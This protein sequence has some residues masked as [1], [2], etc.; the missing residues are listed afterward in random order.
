AVVPSPAAATAAAKK[1]LFSVPA[2]ALA[3]AAAV[4][5]TTA[6]A[7]SS[8]SQSLTLAAALQTTAITSSP[9]ASEPVAKNVAPAPAGQSVE[10]IK[11]PPVQAIPLTGTE[12]VRGTISAQVGELATNS[13]AFSASSNTPSAQ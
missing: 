13:T 6:S 7:S 3:P 2:P 4:E 9:A 11:P 12:P 5:Q 10:P 8:L 1:E